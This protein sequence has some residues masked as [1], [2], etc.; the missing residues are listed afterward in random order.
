M[1]KPTSPTT[2]YVANEIDSKMRPTMKVAVDRRGVAARLL[3]IA[4]HAQRT[5]QAPLLLELALDLAQN[6]LFVF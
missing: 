1:T 6:P 5:R 2:Q 4:R 3:G